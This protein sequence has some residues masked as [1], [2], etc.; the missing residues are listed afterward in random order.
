MYLPEFVLHNAQPYQEFIIR[1]R[2]A[3][4]P[5]VYVSR[6][7]GDFRTLADEVRESELA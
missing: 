2:R 1:T 4:F 6:R 5:D 3:R 7:Y